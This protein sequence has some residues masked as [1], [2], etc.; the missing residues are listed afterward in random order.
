MHEFRQQMI[1]LLQVHGRIAVWIFELTLVLGQ[2]RAGG[3]KV[4]FFS[5][6]VKRQ[7][8]KFAAQGLGITQLA[9]FFAQMRAAVFDAQM[10]MD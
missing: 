6:R 7:W 8:V 1:H 10:L 4:I 3:I 9:T 2:Q 5:R